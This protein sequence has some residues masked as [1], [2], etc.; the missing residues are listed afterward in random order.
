MPAGGV[1]SV[2]TAPAAA[3]NALPPATDRAG[4]ETS[5]VPAA[6]TAGAVVSNSA[7]PA[8]AAHTVPFGIS[9]S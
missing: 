3:L 7:A 8:E 9:A 2:S 4:A 5:S 6:S 1:T